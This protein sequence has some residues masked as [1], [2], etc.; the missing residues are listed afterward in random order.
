[1][2]DPKASLAFYVDAL[3]LKVIREIK[4]PEFKY[5]LYFLAPEGQEE[6]QV[7]SKNVETSACSES[8]ITNRT[9][10]GVRKRSN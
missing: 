1:M 2:T 4:R 7:S 10:S 8:R 3:G 9:C 6:A 5:D